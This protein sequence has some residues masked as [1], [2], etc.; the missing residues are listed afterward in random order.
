MRLKKKKTKTYPSV[1]ISR[2]VWWNQRQEID[3][4]ESNDTAKRKT[5]NHSYCSLAILYI[6]FL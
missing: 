2:F 1:E 6:I 5:F 3:V 4:V